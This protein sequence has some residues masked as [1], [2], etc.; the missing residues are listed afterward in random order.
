MT[1]PTN[2]TAVKMTVAAAHTPT[3]C[4]GTLIV[5]KFRQRQNTAAFRTI[6]FPKNNKTAANNN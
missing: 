2:A 5:K 6:P 1:T 3:I 4:P